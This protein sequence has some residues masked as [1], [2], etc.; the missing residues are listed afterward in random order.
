MADGT[1]YIYA[2]ITD[3]TS[4]DTRYAQGAIAI[5]RT[6]PTVAAKPQGGTYTE[7]QS[8]ILSASEAANIYY[9]MDG[10]SEPTTD[11][12]PYTLPIEVTETTTIRFM[13]V[14]VVGNRGNIVTEVYTIGPTSNVPPEAHAGDDITI[15][16]GDEALLSG[17]ANDPDGG[18][19]PLTYSWQFV[20]LP[21][22]S[23][24]SNEDISG[25][26]TISASFMPD[27]C[28]SYEIELTV[29]DSLDFASDTLAVTVETG[30][31]VQ[32]DLDGDTDVDYD[33]YLIFRTAYG[34]CESDVNFLSG[35]D[36]DG[37][38]CV[39]INDYRILRSLM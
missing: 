21:S 7:I 31:S 10:S 39:T 11:S 6:P 8:V 23:V 34:S 22:E 33:D 20:N 30:A 27:V 37:D 3:G 12:L 17:S 9:T 2:T 15:Y 13:A 32:G 36:F 14:D 28:G 19:G 5:D 16:L 24:L 25:A 35:A 4:S 18:P 38:G 1:Y 26:D 29:S